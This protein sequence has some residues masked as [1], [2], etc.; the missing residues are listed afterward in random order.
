VLAAL[1]WLTLDPFWFTGLNERMVRSRFCG[2]EVGIWFGDLTISAAAY[3]QRATCEN[4]SRLQ[5]TPAGSNPS[6]DH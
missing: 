6:I 5:P 2:S 4:S 1:Q 3:S